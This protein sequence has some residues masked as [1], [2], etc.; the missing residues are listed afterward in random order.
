MWNVFLLSLRTLQPLLVL[1]M[2][3]MV[4]WAVLSRQ[5]WPF[6]IDAETEHL[7]LSLARGVETNWRIDGAVLC[8]R[9]SIDSLKDRSIDKSKIC[10][11]SR[12]NAY[13]LSGLAEPVMVVPSLPDKTPAY[14]A[15]IDMSTDGSLLMQ[16]RTDDPAGPPISLSWADAEAPSTIG[17]DVILEF[18][19]TT[20]ESARRVLLPF[21]GS[22]SIGKDVSWKDSAILRS[23]R[24]SLYTHS[25]DAAG[26][27]AL[28]DTAELM[29]GDRVDLSSGRQSD[30]V[31]I[32]GFIHV[33]V[34]PRAED[35]P[36]I[37][38][39][40]AF[41]ESESVH[42]VRFGDQGYDF[43][44]GIMARLSRHDAISTWAVL[45]LSLLGLMAVYR[46]GSEIGEGTLRESVQRFRERFR[47]PKPD[48]E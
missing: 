27:R 11:S 30:D 22:G 17:Q 16:L 35:S 40:V 23:G 5:P 33:D 21:V 12:W 29:P 2:L 45:I 9:T 41:G 4:F 13:S 6:S 1:A 43:A 18:S 15:S 19:A 24:V 47:K 44:P 25:D 28:V 7:S 46:E 48:E 32:K 38:R 42:I 39:V 37:M 10:A 20:L 34:T 3:A 8:S 26:G 31:P 14:S 36:P